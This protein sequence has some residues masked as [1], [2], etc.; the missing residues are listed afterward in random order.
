[1]AVY[2]RGSRGAEVRR[3]QEELAKYGL[4]SGPLDGIYGGGTESA[5][6]RFQRRS[7]LLVDGKV[8]EQTWG[9]LFGDEPVAEPEIV[10]KGL[11]YRCLALTGAFE[12]SRPVPDCFSGVT[13]DF[14]GQGLS[15]GVL[16]W[17]LWQGSLQPLFKEMAH[18]HPSL[19]EEVCHEHYPELK[20][21][22]TSSPE[23]QMSWVRS[24][25]DPVRHRI[26]EPWYGLL[27]T[28]G[29]QQEF[30]QIQVKHAQ[31]L[32]RS[33]MELCREY[34]L[35]SQRAVAL[36]FDIKVQNGSIRSLTKVQIER[37]FERLPSTLS[38]QELEVARMEIV[39]NRRA[40]AA[41][42]R[43][44]EDVRRRKLTIARGEGIVHGHNYFLWEQ[45][46]L[47]LE[48]FA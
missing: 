15:F 30:Q 11:D 42:S 4:Y 6:A 17:N 48:P 37:D 34:G 25:Q 20:A 10:R 3:I 43:W 2:C 8:G 27:K 44:V 12:T 23:E 47:G 28:L 31:G 32:Y 39:A 14:D 40:E 45:Y 18:S 26:E 21:V 22:F 16:Q 29:R 13:G 19:L 33:A 36:M 1:M 41:S 24:V 5:V 46:G 35:W 9:A 7:D 38:P